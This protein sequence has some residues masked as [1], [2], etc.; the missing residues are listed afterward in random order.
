LGE[1]S[2]LAIGLVYAGTSNEAILSELIA[3]AKDT[4]HEKITRSICMS[5][6]LICFQNPSEEFLNNL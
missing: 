4:E 3:I 1:A 2:A 6:G 5:I